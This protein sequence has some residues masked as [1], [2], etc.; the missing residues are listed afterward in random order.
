MPHPASEGLIES[1][2][3]YVTSVL[4]L[5]LAS[6]LVAAPAAA[7]PAITGAATIEELRARLQTIVSETGTPGLGVAIVWKDGTEST[8][9][10][11][12]ADVASKEPATERTLFRVGSISKGVVALA[13]LQLV[14]QGKL[15]LDDSVRKLAPEVAFENPWEATDPVVVADLLEHTT[16]WEDLRVSE[17]AKDAPGMALRDALAVDPRSRVSRW[18][19]GTRTSYCNS[20]PTVAAYLVEKLTGV[21]FE[22]YVAEHLFRPIGMS[23][24]TYSEHGPARLATLYHVDGTTP[25]PYWNFLY[26]PSG[27]LNA[28]ASDMAAYLRFY[29]GRG[30]VGDVE[31][32]P[33]ASLDRMERHTRSWLAAQGIVANNGLGTGLSMRRGFVYYGHGGAV[34]GGLSQLEY[35]ADG[36]AAY[37]YSINSSNEVA[38][39]QVGDELR[40]FLTK[41][42]APPPAAPVGPPPPDAASYEGWYQPA[43]PRNETN[44]YVEL[45]LGMQRVTWSSGAFRVNNLFGGKYELL[46]AGGNRLRFKMDAGPGYPLPTSALLPP[47]PDGRFVYLE[48]WLERIPAWLV[49]VRLGALMYCLLALAALL[50]AA[51]F[52]LL[53]RGST[54]RSSGTAERRLLS[55]PVIS[56]LCLLAVA[57]L[58]MPAPEDPVATFGA[59]TARSLGLFASTL[60]FAASAVGSAIQWAFL[61]ESRVRPSVRGLTLLSTIALL[62][63]AAYLGYFGIIGIR[64]WA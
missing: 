32:L 60:V 24:A 29:L 49:F 25:Y 42:L 63:I 62:A 57:R 30:T 33:A 36:S 27:S 20:G 7:Q 55:W 1:L 12:L 26:R 41:E 22:Q 39:G 14:N 6:L 16:G 34:R 23:T 52:L 56:A 35:L 18:R 48:A 21:A 9:G 3:K 19:P 43:A 5:L 17:F 10:L 37:F 54:S 4:G 28:S 59:M 13:V 53:R 38:Y 11:G 2:K 8:F 45:L 61:Y 64:T 46:P 50:F 44:R 40:A 58:G 15:S 31:V 47:H 51:P